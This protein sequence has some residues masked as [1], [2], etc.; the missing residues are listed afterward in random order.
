MTW[1]DEVAKVLK[2]FNWADDI[3]ESTRGETNN[4]VDIT[5]ALYTM[6]MNNLNQSGNL[7][8][9][10]QS[11][12]IEGNN[13]YLDGSECD[14]N[15][16]ATM[17]IGNYS[18]INA[19]ALLEATASAFAKIAYDL[20]DDIK[21]D[22]K[23]DIMKTIN[24]TTKSETEIKN[25]LIEQILQNCNNIEN[26][27]KIKF[28]NNNVN[29]KCGSFDIT[30]KNVQKLDCMINAVSDV[31][32]DIEATIQNKVV[33]ETGSNNTLLIIIVVIVVIIVI[34]IFCV[35][36]YFVFSRKTKI[37]KNVVNSTAKKRKM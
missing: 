29:I 35:I 26:Y 18:E 25:E 2:G 7:E 10:N 36:M 15:Q 3:V 11:N 30:N 8:Y 22:V 4:T 31:K 5:K 20:K 21:N 24:T 9:T 16:P 27:Q 6:T 37:V 28:L 1:G 12:T 19:D 34:I 17:S 14:S 23:S 33:T 13:F 32:Q